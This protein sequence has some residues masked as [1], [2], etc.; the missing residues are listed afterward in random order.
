MSLRDRES[1][2]TTDVAVD[3]GSTQSIGAASAELLAA[4]PDRVRAT[5]HNNHATQIVWISFGK[6]AVVGEGVKIGPGVTWIESEFTGAVNGIAS[7]AATP[8]A[9]T[10]L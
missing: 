10:D 7:G 2:E 5:L 8:V 3:G 4:N 6:A 9:K 1:V